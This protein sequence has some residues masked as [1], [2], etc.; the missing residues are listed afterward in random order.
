MQTSH[1]TPVYD[2]ADTLLFWAE[3]D[4]VPELMRK[5]NATVIAV[6]GRIRAIRLAPDPSRLMS[7]SHARRQ[8]AQ[9]HRAENYYNPKGCWT[10]DRVPS[11]FRYCYCAVI[12]SLLCTSKIGM[13]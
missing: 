7:G 6:N 9:P 8:L 13:A 4:R 11:R 5:P 12:D 1:R 10:I 2:H 3:R